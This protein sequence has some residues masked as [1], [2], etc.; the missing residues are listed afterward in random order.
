MTKTALVIGVNKYASTKYVSLNGAVPDALAVAECLLATHQFDSVRLS[1]SFDEA[2]AA[3]KQRVADVTARG[4]GKVTR[5]GAPTRET[6][7]SELARLA[8]AAQRNDDDIVVIYYSGHGGSIQAQGTHSGYVET[9]VACDDAADNMSHVID[10]EL[11]EH[12]A[13]INKSRTNDVVLMFDS[14]HSGD[15]FRRSRPTKCATPAPTTKPA[16][17]W[18]RSKRPSRFRRR[19]LYC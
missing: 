16:R 13:L 5:V 9:M 1:L 3:L 4:Q 15:I 11:R 17:C 7:L 10:V 8:E 19:R 14:C 12:V 18:R 2:N 6:I